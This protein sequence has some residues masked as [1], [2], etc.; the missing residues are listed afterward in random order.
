MR[1]RPLLLTLL[2]LPWSQGC[3]PLL[4]PL[5]RAFGSPAESELKQRRA[6]FDRLKARRATAQI[7]VAPVLDPRRGNQPMDSTAASLANQLQ[8]DGWAGASALSAAPDVAATPLGRNQLRYLQT[9]AQAYA[10]WTRA[11]RPDGDYLLVVE[12]LSGPAGIAGVHC[13]VLENSGQVAYLCLQN[14]HHFGG[15]PPADAHAAG[16]LALRLLARDLERKAVEVYP[17]WGVG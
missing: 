15:N 5:A 3:K 17:P 11:A 16:R 14:S 6:A 10:D 13:Y 9:R 4:Y 2:F 7:R 1:L 8:A 12:V